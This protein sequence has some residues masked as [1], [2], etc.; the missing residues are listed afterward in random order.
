VPL[1]ACRGMGRVGAISFPYNP[2]RQ[3]WFRHLQCGRAS[4]RFPPKAG[5]RCSGRRSLVCRPARAAG[6]SRCAQSGGITKSFSTTRSDLCRNTLQCAASLTAWQAAPGPPPGA[7]HQ[8]SATC[9][10]PSSALAALRA[11]R[12]TGVSTAAEAASLDHLLVG[13]AAHEIDAL[14]RQ[15]RLA[16]RSRAGAFGP[17]ER[18][19]SV[20]P[21]R[22]EHLTVP[23]R[24]RR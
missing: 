11:G 18:I 1:H 15:R 20:G 24:T 6:R 10:A 4:V 16:P 8:T 2:R 17:T 19:G 14:P 12:A 5:I 22:S 9:P 23:D 7:L 13:I 21:L 3:N